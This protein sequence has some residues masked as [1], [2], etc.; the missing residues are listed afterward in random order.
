MEGNTKGRRRL[1]APALRGAAGQRLTPPRPPAA[2]RGRAPRWQRAGA[3]AQHR[4]APH[5]PTGGDH[6]LGVVLTNKPQVEF[7]ASGRSARPAPGPPGRTPAAAQPLPSTSRRVPA[8]GRTG[9]HRAAALTGRAGPGPT[10]QDG[11]GRFAPRPPNPDPDPATEHPHRAGKARPAGSL[12]G[13]RGRRCAF[14]RESST[15]TI[16]GPLCGPA[17]AGQPANGP[18]ETRNVGAADG[19]GARPAAPGARGV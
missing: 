13:W 16:N 19:L 3:P 2:L 9:K 7:P 15:Y 14:K 18:I 6:G 11:A 17:P 1:R 4:G 8:N 12:A 5:R 10:E